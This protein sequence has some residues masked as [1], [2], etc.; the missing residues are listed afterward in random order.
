MESNTIEYTV[1]TLVQFGLLAS[2][3]KFYQEWVGKNCPHS[4]L[5]KMRGTAFKQLIADRFKKL[6]RPAIAKPAVEQPE[7]VVEHAL[8]AGDKVFNVLYV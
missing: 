7:P 1:H 6:K 4:I 5:D 3:V 2:S 8:I